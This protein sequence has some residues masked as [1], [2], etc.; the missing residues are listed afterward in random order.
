MI[1]TQVTKIQR[2]SSQQQIQKHQPLQMQ[3]FCQ[4]RMTQKQSRN[5]QALFQTR[6][7]VQQAKSRWGSSQMHQQQKEP[8]IVSQNH[9]QQRQQKMPKIANQVSLTNLQQKKSIHIVN[10]TQ[11]KDTHI[12][13]TVAYLLQIQQPNGS[14]NNVSLI[15][16]LVKYKIKRTNN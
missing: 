5:Q 6:A 16:Q 10:Q 13:Q 15:K 11:Q 7:P 2:V 14:W 4:Q 3:L 1:F 9:I 12:D 8:M